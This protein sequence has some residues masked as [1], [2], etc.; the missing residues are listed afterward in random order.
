MIRKDKILK[1]AR[2][3]EKEIISLRDLILEMCDDLDKEETI[4]KKEIIHLAVV[5]S[6]EDL[7]KLSYNHSEL[8]NQL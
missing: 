7:N 2:N 8:I 4:E 1:S 5:K 3:L 6:I